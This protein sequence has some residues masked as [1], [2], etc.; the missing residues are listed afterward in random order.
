MH[1][2]KQREEFGK[3]LIAE[4]FRGLHNGYCER[5]RTDKLNRQLL[6]PHSVHFLDM[7]CTMNPW[8]LDLSD[9]DSSISHGTEVLC[10]ATGEF[11][12]STIGSVPQPPQHGGSFPNWDTFRWMQS[13]PLLNH[14]SSLPPDLIHLTDNVRASIRQPNCRDHRR[15]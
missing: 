11:A 1:R 12:L 15:R 5:R 6:E 10:T 7:L 14:T 9:D 2:F 13:S 4:D 8:I 3:R